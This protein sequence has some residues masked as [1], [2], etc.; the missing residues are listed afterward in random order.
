MSQCIAPFGMQLNTRGRSV[1]P[2]ATQIASL[3][4][5]PLQHDL[6]T[7][8]S[9]PLQRNLETVHAYP[10]QR[11]L[12]PVGTYSVQMIA[13]TLNPMGDWTSLVGG[14]LNSVTSGLFNQVFPAGGS[15][16]GAGGGLGGNITITTPPAQPAPPV[17]FNWTPVII[18]GG[19]VLVALTL[20]M[21]VGKKH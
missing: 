4:A 12:D 13:R 2:F 6:E 17:P 5:Y 10:L 20:I 21:T 3:S 9:Y 14:A 11:N 16:G 18:S 8:H 19:V 15:G 7:V 1:N